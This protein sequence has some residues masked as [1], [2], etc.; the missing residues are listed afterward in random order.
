MDGATLLWL[1]FR[2]LRWAL[3]IAFCGYTLY[4]HLYRATI[5]TALNQLPNHVALTIYGLAVGA[6]FAGFFELMMRE[7]AGLARPDFLRM[8]KRI[9]AEG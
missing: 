3:W 6:V 2:V 5:F 9:P 1:F 4:V 8:A 7:K